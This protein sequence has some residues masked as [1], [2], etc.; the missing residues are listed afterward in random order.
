MASIYFKQ[1]ENR[2][3]KAEYLN[4]AS[5]HYSR[6]GDRTPHLNVVAIN[7]GDY[8][9][10]FAWSPKS[11]EAKELARIRGSGLLVLVD[12]E[13]PVAAQHKRRRNG[14]LN[15]LTRQVRTWGLLSN[16]E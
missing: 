8:G 6:K 2:E 16:Y 5:C 9:G 12:V 3:L 13:L 4:I 11:G 15:I 10:S 14:V 7:H 1:H